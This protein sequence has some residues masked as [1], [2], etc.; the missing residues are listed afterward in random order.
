[1]LSLP[2]VFT[3]SECFQALDAGADGLKF[4]P[5]S[6]L[7]PRNFKAL[8]AVLPNRH[9]SLRA[10]AV[11]EVG[12]SRF[13]LD[14]P[15]SSPHIRQRSAHSAQLARSTRSQSRL[16]RS[17]TSFETDTARDIPSPR[18][19]RSHL[20]QHRAPRAQTPALQPPPKPPLSEVEKFL[21][22]WYED[23]PDCERIEIPDCSIWNPELQK[24]GAFPRPPPPPP[25]GG[26]EES[27][28]A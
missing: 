24:P 27:K 22:R 12:P 26:V 7:K 3:T 15:P 16:A 8:S 4:F 2:G 20:P 19:P 23:H 10:P 28:G 13:P 14:A 17:R 9:L 18:T 5:A 21:E 11:L 6:L 25:S 1:M